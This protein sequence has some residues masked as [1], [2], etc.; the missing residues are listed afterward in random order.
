ME[1]AKEFLDAVVAGDRA[2]VNSL[3]A[4]DPTLASARNVNGDSAVMLAVYRGQREIAEILVGAGID[5]DLHEAA[6]VGA[7]DRISAL[8][9][10]SPGEVDAYS[11]DGWTPLH[12]AAFFGH[13]EATRVLV[14]G[15]AN[16]GARSHSEVAPS[17]TPLHASVAA[18]HREI[19]RRLIGA[20][21]DCKIAD[22]HGNTPLHIAAHGGDAEVVRMLLDAGADS[23]HPNDSGTTPLDMAE[24]GGHLDAAA[25]LVSPPV[26]GP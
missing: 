24:D 1:R 17:N 15:G 4:E 16:L 10:A 23:R 21:A 2:L 9:E 18:G 22:A 13:M 11:H 20:G 12:L 8:L 26:A 3:L 14:E 6:A 25:L 7:A 5:L 19:V